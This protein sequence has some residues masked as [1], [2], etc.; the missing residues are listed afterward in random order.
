MSGHRPE[1]AEVHA[2]WNALG[3]RIGESARAKPIE[4]AVL[5]VR[6]AAIASD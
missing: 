3:V 1:A 5:L 6:T 4:P 2:G